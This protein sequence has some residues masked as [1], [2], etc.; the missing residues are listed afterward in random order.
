MKKNYIA[1][2]INIVKVRTN[3]I[4]QASN[5]TLSTESGDAITTS[6]GFGARRFNSVWGDDDNE[7]E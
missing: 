5:A 3:A 7:D 4:M 2:E 1:P 6:D